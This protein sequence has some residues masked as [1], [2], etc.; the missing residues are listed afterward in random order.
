[1]TEKD[2]KYEKEHLNELKEMVKTR[3]PDEA[4]GEVLAVFC[5]RHGLS[6]DECEKYYEQLVAKGEIRKK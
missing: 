5:H 2:D 4:V 1:M 3:K 6:I